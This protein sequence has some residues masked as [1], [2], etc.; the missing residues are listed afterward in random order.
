MTCVRIR[1]DESGLGDEDTTDEDSASAPH[2][3]LTLAYHKD[4]QQRE[5]GQ[6]RVAMEEMNETMNMI[7]KRLDRLQRPPRS[8]TIDEAATLKNGRA[9]ARDKE[10]IRKGDTDYDEKIPTLINTLNKLVNRM[11]T[12]NYR[13][14]A[15]NIGLCNHACTHEQDKD[16]TDSASCANISEFADDNETGKKESTNYGKLENQKQVVHIDL[17]QDT[18]QITLKDGKLERKSLEPYTLLANDLKQKSDATTLD[19]WTE[20]TFSGF[21]NHLHGLQKKTDVKQ[22]RNKSDEQGTPISSGTVIH[23]VSLGLESTQT[24]NRSKDTKEDV[25]LITGE[26]TDIKHQ[27]QTKSNKSFNDGFNL[28]KNEGV[29]LEEHLKYANNQTKEIKPSTSIHQTK[30]HEDAMGKIVSTE[31]SVDQDSE[32]QGSVTISGPI[33]SRITQSPKSPSEPIMPWSHVPLEYWNSLI[34]ETREKAEILKTSRPMGLNT[35]ICLDTSKSVAEYWGD[36][37]EFFRNLIN[38]IDVIQPIEGEIMEHIAVVTFGHETCVLQ[39][40]STDYQEILTK[41]H[42]I[43]PEGST[44]M[45]WVLHMCEAILSETYVPLLR[46]F[47]INA[48]LLLVTDGRP[49][50]RFI[51]GGQDVPLRYQEEELEKEDTA[52]KLIFL[53]S[54]IPLLRV[55]PVTVGNNCDM[56]F[57][58]AMADSTRGK[59]MTLS[60][61]PEIA[62]FGKK[63]ELTSKYFGLASLP[64]NLLSKVLTEKSGLPQEE[65]EFITGAIEDQIKLQN[66]EGYTSD[67]EQMKSSYQFPPVGSRVRRGPDWNR[68][69]EDNDSPGTLYGYAKGKALS[70]WVMVQWDR[71]KKYGRWRFCY[72]YGAE[73]AHDIEIQAIEEPR[74]MDSFWDVR[75]GCE[76]IKGRYRNLTDKETDDVDEGSIGMVYEM[77]NMGGDI[78]IKVRW[79]NGKRRKYRKSSRELELSPRS[80]PSHLSWPLA[81]LPPLLNPFITTRQPSLDISRQ[82]LTRQDTLPT[83]W[84]Q[85]TRGEMQNSDSEDEVDWY[86]QSSS[87]DVGKEREVVRIE[88]VVR[89]RMPSVDDM[90]SR[91]QNFT[92]KKESTIKPTFGIENLKS[93]KHKVTQQ[94]ELYG[95]TKRIRTQIRNKNAHV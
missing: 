28:K 82:H 76:V 27:K 72:R 54:S 67:E 47:R 10:S 91:N 50:D 63:L 3:H 20:E 49:T 71:P 35:I 69:D 9:R 12:L 78:E 33:V 44:P 94:A 11:D 65:I 14:E 7:V 59:V 16:E 64:G 34:Q 18:M 42:M 32:T 86:N 57:L 17:T 41:I 88:D 21:K 1:E 75:T 85:S 24:E 68:K 8:R 38:E 62:H 46:D 74:I 58:S 53:N 73:N 26:N 70:G 56:E 81:P 84:G 6:L 25:Q 19:I 93:D 13:L 80:R 40:F 4:L 79:R 22:V 51:T 61:W 52:R 5:Q 66:N 48:R 55:Y 30:G 83:S 89:H 92:R 45:Y 87:S 23:T 39:H 43:N 77:L 95:T 31:M 36:I 15:G 37:L 90:N 29:R 2:G 60:D